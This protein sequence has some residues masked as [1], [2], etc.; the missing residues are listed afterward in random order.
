MAYT[1]VVTKQS[2]TQKSDKIYTFSIE[3]AV[4]DGATDV[5][6]CRASE[7]YN[8]Q[9]PDLEGVKQRLTG[10]LKEQWDKYAVENNLFTAPAF[11]LMVGE[12]ETSANTYINL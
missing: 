7:Q 2:V 8:K 10:Q 9:T 11:D 5:F 6:T 12:I 3:M 4:N 1:A